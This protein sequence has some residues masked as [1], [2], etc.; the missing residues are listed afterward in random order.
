MPEI[1]LHHFAASPFSEKI[2]RI[3]GYKQLAWAS[4]EIPRILPKPEL[5]PLTGGYRRTPVMQIG[6]DVYCDTRLIARTLDRLAPEPPLFVSTLRASITAL[7]RWAD[8]QLFLAAIPVLFRPAGR[9]AL[10]DKLGAD[11][12]ERFQAD[13][14]AL[15]RGGHVGRPDDQFSR[16][17]WEPAMA[18]LDA[19][20]HEQPFLLGQTPTLADF[21]VYHPVWYVRGNAGV[22]ATLDAYPQL[23]HWFERMGEF[24][25]G[26]SE[27]M[28]GAD[29]LARARHS[30]CWQPVADTRDAAFGPHLGHAV[31][32]AATDYGVDPV[33]GRLV[34]IDA[35]TVVVE[36]EAPTVGPL[37]VHFPRTGFRI[38][39]TG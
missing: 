2:R 13:R 7:E 26:R 24:G 1:V 4:V 28:T 12:L 6:R 33:V 35:H 30:D 17:L 14:A 18:D 3:L 25:H 19:Q 32:V 27:P 11:Y 9:A 31:E 5:M 23:V 8:Q 16:G 34:Q 36:R 22:A 37:R 15:F 10:V 20:L 21:A 39:L 38:R 29:A